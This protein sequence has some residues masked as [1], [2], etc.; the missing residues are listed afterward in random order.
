VRGLCLQTIE[1]V[2]RLSDYTGTSSARP[3]GRDVTVMVNRRG[4][5]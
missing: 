1:W 3:F 2:P 4:L 5:C